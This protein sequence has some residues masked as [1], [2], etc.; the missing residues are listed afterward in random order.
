MIP[1]RSSEAK[2]VNGP[3]RE[4]RTVFLR[5]ASVLLTIKFFAAR[6]FAHRIGIGITVILSRV[7]GEESQST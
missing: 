1:S 4:L 7:D 5:A 2:T 3:T 6:G